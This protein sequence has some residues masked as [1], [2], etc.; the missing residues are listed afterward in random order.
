MTIFNDN[1]ALSG[2]E[3]EDNYFIIDG[4]IREGLFEHSSDAKEYLGYV[5]Y[6]GECTEKYL[7]EY[8]ADYSW[9]YDEYEEEEEDYILY[10]YARHK[11]IK[12]DFEND[13]PMVDADLYIK[14]TKLGKAMLSENNPYEF[15]EFFRID[16]R[17]IEFNKSNV[18]SEDDRHYRDPDVAAYCYE[19]VKKLID[20]NYSI[21]KALETVKG[22]LLGEAAWQK[23]C[24]WKPK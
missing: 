11:K 1:G 8:Y 3:I 24:M 13:E 19:S 9:D 18:V 15:E 20:Q 4:L 22:V 5:I 17:V 7:G 23:V 12:K 14:H 10:K 6:H 21:D 16:N 2:Q